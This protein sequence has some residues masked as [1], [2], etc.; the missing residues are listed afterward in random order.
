MFY[1]FLPFGCG[2]C[3]LWL[4]ASV[5]LISFNLSFQLRLFID[6]EL[7]LTF[8]SDS[9][10]FLIR[11]VLSSFEITFML[12]SSDVVFLVVCD[13]ITASLLGCCGWIST[14]SFDSTFICSFGSSTIISLM[15]S[16]I[17]ISSSWSIV[18]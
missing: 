7:K 13:L 5:L 8:S 2:T 11:G 3:F 16:S 14:S 17:I 9:F 1:R 10:A 6:S 15:L 12:W 4:F 18:I